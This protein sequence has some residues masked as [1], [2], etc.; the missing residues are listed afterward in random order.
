MFFEMADYSE[1]LRLT[2]LT[3]KLVIGV[4]T[5][6]LLAKSNPALPALTSG[7]APGV[8]GKP[9]PDTNNMV[10]SKEYEDEASAA[11]ENSA[12]YLAA[13]QL[14][15]V[16]EEKLPKRFEHPDRG[17]RNACSIIRVLKVSFEEN[18]YSPVWKF[19]DEWKGRLLEFEKVSLF[20]PELDGRPVRRRD[21]GGPLTLL[22]LLEFVREKVV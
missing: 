2:E 3:L 22:R 10:L 5:R 21:Y 7:V 1:R 15:S 12:V 8:K 13:C 18:P 19:P 6:A 14:D 20:P 11:L 16:L 17:L 9:P 4:R